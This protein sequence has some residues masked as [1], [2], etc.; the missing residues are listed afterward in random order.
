[1]ARNNIQDFDLNSLSQGKLDTHDKD[2]QD[3]KKD[4]Q[5]ENILKS[6]LPIIKNSGKDVRDAFKVVI[7]DLTKDQLWKWI[8]GIGSII[9][10]AIISAVISYVI[11][12]IN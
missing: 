5:P 4:I 7:E 12:K 10:S 1:M 3:L 8:V 6:I 9:V 11:S 2:I